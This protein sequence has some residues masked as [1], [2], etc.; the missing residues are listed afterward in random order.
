MFHVTV[1]DLHTYTSSHPLTM[2]LYAKGA[3]RRLVSH[4]LIPLENA[5]D[6]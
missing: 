1:L 3:I 6:G 4:F 2:L 5:P